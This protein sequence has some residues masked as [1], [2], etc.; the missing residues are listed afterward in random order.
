MHNNITIIYVIYKSG[1]IF[2][3]NIKRLNN[4]K[5]IIIDND[6]N[7]DLVDKIKKIDNSVDYTRL[8]KNIGMAKAANLAFDKV[9]TE[10]F[11]YLTADTIIDEHNIK[12]L[13][14]IFLKYES[15][16]LSS[17]VHLGSDKTYL[18]NYSCHPINRFLNR[19]KN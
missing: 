15:V 13:L 18:G 17:P 2:F 8:N 19:N 12:N 3:E 10:F 4:F 6:P 14:K 16:G 1:D 5:K 9:K 7:S 11:L